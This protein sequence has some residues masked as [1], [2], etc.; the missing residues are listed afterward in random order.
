MRD[1]VCDTYL[2]GQLHTLRRSSRPDLCRA[3][4]PRCR[5]E[6]TPPRTA[7][8]RGSIDNLDAALV[9]LLAERFKI[10][11][12]VG[13]LKA[14][15]G[16]PPADPAREAAADRPAPG[17]GRATRSWTPSSPRS[18]WT[19]SWPRSSGTT[20]PCRPRSADPAPDLDRRPGQS[21]APGQRSSGGP[22]GE[23]AAA[24]ERALQRRGSR[25]CRR[26]RS[27]PPRRRRR[28][29]A[30]ASR[31][32]LSTRASRSVSRPPSVL[33]VSTCSRTA[34][35]GPPAGPA[36]PGRWVEQ[37][38]RRRHP[39]QPV[40]E[41]VPGGRGRHDLRV[42]AEPACAPAG[43]GPRSAARSASGVDQ[44]LADQRVHLAASSA[45]EPAVRKSTPAVEERLH[46]RRGT[47]PDPAR[48]AAAGPCR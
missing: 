46:L 22:A 9:Y 43:R 17:A 29:R 41:E 19:S 30:A 23:Q 42:L 8:L 10:T 6:R 25:A 45:T 31:P 48:P 32:A 7:R 26:R 15:N 2:A 37:R 39:H 13:L 16:L 4:T 3:A 18:S 27:R 1:T 24:Q 14:A 12:Q 34:I 35:S 20:R 5:H 40:A 33:R 36:S 38:V 44:V 28:A 47:R 11:Q 21:R